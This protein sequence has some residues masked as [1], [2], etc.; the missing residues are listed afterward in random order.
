MTTAT[1]TEK[2]TPEEMLFVVTVSLFI[3]KPEHNK[4]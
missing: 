3:K 2:A 4:K 1:I